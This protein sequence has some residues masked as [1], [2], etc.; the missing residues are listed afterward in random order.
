MR[1]II[2][3]AFAVLAAAG[4]SKEEK[5]NTPGTTQTTTGGE[6]AT[7]AP[8]QESASIA[9][10]MKV[11]GTTVQA[12]NVEGGAALIFTTSRDIDALREHVRNFAAMQEAQGMRG[13]H[14]GMSG[15]MR[16][17]GSPSAGAKSAEP[18]NDEQRGG[19]VYGGADQTAGGG[20]SAKAEVEGAMAMPQVN[21]RVE[22]IDGGAR[23]VIIPMDSNDLDTVRMQ[24]EEQAQTMTRGQCP[25]MSGTGME[26]NN[27]NMNMGNESQSYPEE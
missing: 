12:E 18:M 16:P 14:A 9:C 2:V 10:P 11:M 24:V 20:S 21:T 26:N 15:T 25:A 8:G 3:A 17:G 1:T 6:T 27:M 7:P 5:T 22:D 13:G 19:S 4:C 23:M